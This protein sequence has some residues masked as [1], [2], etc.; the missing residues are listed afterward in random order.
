MEF[1]KQSL[2]ERILEEAAAAALAKKAEAEGYEKERLACANKEA[3]ELLSLA[4]AEAEKRA[5]ELRA[6]RATLDRLE[7]RKTLLRAKKQ[8]VDGVF[9]RAVEL[10]C[11]MGKED[12]LALVSRLLTVHAAEGERVILAK[13]SPLTAEDVLALPVAKTLHLTAEGGAE[14][15]GGFLLSGKAYDKLFSFTALAEQLREGAE[16]EIASALLLNAEGK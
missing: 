9:C 12:T 11:A 13:N 6:R 14:I 2:S 10:L 4:K 16:S 5:E 15:T 7:G 8:A 3:E 1:Q